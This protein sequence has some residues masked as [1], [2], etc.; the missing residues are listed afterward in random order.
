MQSQQ[1]H[2]HLYFHSKPSSF[3]EFADPIRSQRV[4]HVSRAKRGKKVL[5]ETRAACASHEMRACLCN[6]IPTARFSSTSS[7]KANHRRRSRSGVLL[8][9]F[10]HSPVDVLNTISSMASRKE[11]KCP[12]LLDRLLRTPL[13]FGRTLNITKA[14]SVSA[15]LSESNWM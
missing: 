10:Q 8:S 5:T 1:G 14:R 3:F 13:P 6:P 15:A 2:L 12:C 7:A 9:S 11:N 4:R